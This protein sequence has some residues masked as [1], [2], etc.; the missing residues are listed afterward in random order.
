VCDFGEKIRV[1]AGEKNKREKE[2]GRAE[3]GVVRELDGRVG[4]VGEG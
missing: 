3:V 2:D 1:F 4:N